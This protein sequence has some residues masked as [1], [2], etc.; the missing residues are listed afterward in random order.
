MDSN[1]YSLEFGHQ[2][3][4]EEDKSSEPQGSTEITLRK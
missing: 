1:T 4:P 3:R 2:K